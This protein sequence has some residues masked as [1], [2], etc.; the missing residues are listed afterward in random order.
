M[1]FIDLKVFF[2]LFILLLGSWV[3]RNFILIEFLEKE[4]VF[5]KKIFYIRK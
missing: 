3:R 4:N 5:K 1:V 2:K